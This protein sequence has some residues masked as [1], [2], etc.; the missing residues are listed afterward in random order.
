MSRTLAEAFYESCCSDKSHRNAG[1]THEELLPATEYNL[2]H[3]RGGFR[4]LPHR[5][6]PSAAEVLEALIADPL[7]LI[8]SAITVVKDFLTLR[9]CS[10]PWSRQS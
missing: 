1:A 3:N 10:S 6:R 7:V 5:G 8:L 9:Y 4:Q 2:E